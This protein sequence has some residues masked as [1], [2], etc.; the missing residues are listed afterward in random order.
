MLENVNLKEQIEKEAYKKQIAP[1]KEALFSLE[2][3]L[4]K[5]KLP[6]IILFEGWG[7]AGKGRVIG[8]LIKNFDPRWFQVVSTVPATAEEKR[9]PILRRHFMELPEAS[10]MMIFDR[11][12]YMEVST[13]RLEDEIDDRTN[14]QRI[15]E[16]NAF[17]R[18][19]TNNGYLILKFF[20]HIS[21][22]EQKERFQKLDSDKDT[23]WRVT[24]TDWRRNR[25][26]D[27]YYQIFDEM[28]EATDTDYAPWHVIS[29]MDHRL[30]TLEVLRTVND[31]IHKA[32]QKKAE[33]EKHPAAPSA[34]IDPGNFPILEIQKLSDVSLDKS[35]S[36]QK[37]Q[38]ELK[39][40]QKRLSHLHNVLYLKKMPVIIAYEGW[41]AAGKG[42][43]IRR[44]S[45][46]LDPRGYEVV[47]IAAPNHEEISRHYLWRFWKK[48]PKEGH[49]AI[50]D[51]TWYGRVMV[52]RIEGFCSEGDWHRA[53][54]E[55]NEFEKQLH[56]WGAV[57]LK[58]WL[59]IDQDEQLRRFEKRQN[60][61]SK[62]WKIT[63]E[64]WRNR[65]KWPLYEEAVNDMLKYTNT[66]FAPWH[67]IESNDKYYA[68]IKTLKI[69]NDTLQKALK[70]Y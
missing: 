21:A 19:L 29:G 34:V 8:E 67:I 69:I 55:I 17:E 36:S 14:L 11:S 52:E 45:A 31:E 62:Q 10:Q 37:Y 28:L 58:F 46:A 9:Y 7:A 51:R 70:S 40:E 64:D 12:W 53:Y 56:N 32:L 16:I 49:I 66:Q 13:G 41:D 48:I 61:P 27:K 60:T 2:S 44:V 68:R 42:G 4:K 5:E 23:E 33:Q 38:E 59:Q 6:V 20:L 63:D 35:L 1:I 15:E 47:P 24:S 65:E 43:N 54:R 18:N 22:K 30:C 57:I 3:P 39:A 26:Y 50:F 25:Q